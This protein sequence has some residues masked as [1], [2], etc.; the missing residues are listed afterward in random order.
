MKSIKNI[1]AI[2]LET[3]L[4]QKHSSYQ[5]LSQRLNEMIDVTDIELNPKY[6]RERL[7]YILSKVD[8]EGKTI[9][10]IGCNTG[11]FLFELMD[12]NTISGVGY[13]GSKWHADF[14]KEATNLLELHEKVKIENE[15]YQFSNSNKTKFDIALL[16]NI[17]HHCGDDYD[18]SELS[19]NEAKKTMLTQINN[20][21][22]YADIVIFQMG[23]N[24]KGNIKTCLFEN[25]T[26][27]EMI[28]FIK[29]GTL[30]KYDILDIG[31]ARKNEDKVYYEDLNSQ[32]IQREDL[33]GEF[34][35][36]PLF[37]M[38]SKCFRNETV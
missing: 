23:F 17:V 11:Y 33:L 4:T 27:E 13:E 25:G 14:C 21:S 5:I 6:E 16:L 12:L 26:K 3:T 18:N 10:D 28:N 8:V 22:Q 32:N 35:N 31:I 29:K 30:T 2:F 9:L 19:I 20:I 37:I 15:Y 34:L 38:K 36:R 1:K 24:W 7:D